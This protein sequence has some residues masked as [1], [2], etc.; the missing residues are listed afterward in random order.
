MIKLQLIFIFLKVR[1]SD[2]KYLGRV[3]VGAVFVIDNL[4]AKSC[5][6]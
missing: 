1:C 5:S 2:A 6:C 4:F 3:I